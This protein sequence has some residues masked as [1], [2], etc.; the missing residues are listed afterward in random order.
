M[1]III[2][3][4]SQIEGIRKSCQLA[5]KTL[6]FLEAFVSP[7]TSTE[8]LNTLADEYIRDHGAIPAPLG[9]KPSGCKQGY[10]K[11]ICTS[12]NEVICHGIPAEDAILQ[13]GDILNIDVTTILDGYYGDTS[14]MYRV[15]DISEDAEHLL[16][17][18][19]DSL[20][21]GIAQVRPN[22]FFGNIGYAIYN[23]ATIFNQCSVV[24]QFV[25]HGVGLDFHEEPN[26][27]HIAFKDSGPIMKPGMVFT[28]EPMLNLK[29]PEAMI[30]EDG[31]TAVTRDKSL[32]AQYEHTVLVVENGVEILTTMESE[33]SNALSSSMSQMQ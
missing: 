14:T 24:Y 23:H 17:T 8:S 12:I 4:A 3:T 27:H 30:L 18:C 13:E 16:K 26:V 21:K 32:S 19:R 6:Q 10:P 1:S 22:N 9:Y 25:G 29:G 28:I 20:N 31:W 7:G 2:K 33:T 5:A 11:S 15:G